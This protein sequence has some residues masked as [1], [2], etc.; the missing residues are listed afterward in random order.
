MATII[1]TLHKII[2]RE[3]GKADGRGECLEHATVREMN[4]EG[5][6]AVMT[7]EL[8]RRAKELYPEAFA[9]V[10]EDGDEH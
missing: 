4:R 2:E 1:E 7:P 10:K 5:S 6:P 3:S 9:Q 8:L